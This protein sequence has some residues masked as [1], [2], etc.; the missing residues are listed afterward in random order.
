MNIYLWGYRILWLITF[1]M[2]GISMARSQNHTM[3]HTVLDV[4]DGLSSRT[5]ALFFMG[6]QNRMWMSGGYGLDLYDGSRFTN[7]SVANGHLL[8]NV[9]TAIAE[10]HQQRLWLGYVNEEIPLGYQVQIFDLKTKTSQW[11]TDLV[12]LS[13]LQGKKVQWISPD[14]YRKMLWVI[15]EK[16]LFAYNERGQL[17]EYFVSNR[18][19][20]SAH[21]S[22]KGV[23]IQ[24]DNEFILIDG[25][26][27]QLR[28]FD[29]DPDKNFI[30]IGSDS[31]SNLF[32]FEQ[33]DRENLNKQHIYKNNE[34]FQP[35][36]EYIWKETLFIGINPQQDLIYARKPGTLFVVYD[37][38]LNEVAQL[39][40]DVDFYKHPFHPYF[41][42]YNNWWLAFDKQVHIFN[43]DKV[44]F[45]T[46]LTDFFIFGETGFGSRGIYPANDSTVYVSGLGGTYIIDP[47][48]GKTSELLVPDQ[49]MKGSLL[50][51]FRRMDI[52]ELSDGTLLFS[53]EGDRI[54][55][56]TPGTQRFA[57]IAP[58]EVQKDE[59]GNWIEQVRM[60]WSMLEHGDKVW[61]AQNRLSYFN[62][63]STTHQEFDDYNGYE[64]LASVNIYDLHATSDSIW[65]GSAKGLYLLDPNK[66]IINK[67]PLRAEVVGN[68]EHILHINSYG[69]GKLYLGT[70][71]GVI[72][73]DTASGQVTDRWDVSRGL[74]DN[75]A[76]AVYKDDYG[77]LWVPGNSGLSLVN[78]QN[79]QVQIFREEDGLAH[80]E[81][82]TTS[83]A[84]APDGTLYFGG[85][86]GVTSFH[87]R[88]FPL[89][90]TAKDVLVLSTVRVQK[91][92]SG[93]YSDYN[94]I[95]GNETRL[96]LRPSD[97]GLELKFGIQDYLSRE[98]ESFAYKIE[99]LG[100][101]WI[102]AAS[103]EIRINRLH[104]GEYRLLVKAQGANGELFAT[105]AFG[106]TVV[107]PFHLTGW[108][109]TLV[110]LI[111]VGLVVMVVRYREQLLK[112]R[113][114]TLENEIDLATREIQEQA[115]ELRSLDK[116]KSN[117]FAN[118]SHELKT[119]LSL[120]LAP[121]E[122]AIG[123][124]VLE[125]EL[126]SDLSLAH[127]NAEMIKKLV[128][129]I[130]D[131]TRLE[132][133]VAQPRYSRVK[134]NTF[135]RSIV[136]N[137]DHKAQAGKID[138]NVI[139]NLSEDIE[140]VL[141]PTMTEK[142]IN[143]LISN[144]LRHTSQGEVILMVDANEDLNI[145]VK[146]S[147]SGISE[148]DLPYVFDRFFQT[149][150]PNK[151]A[152]GG[153][154]IGLALS[155]ELAQAMHGDLQVESQLNQG[156]TF[157]LSLP[158]IEHFVSPTSLPQNESYEDY[159]LLIPSKRTILVVED[160]TDL[161]TFILSSLKNQFDLLA[162]A[163]G[164]EALEKLRQ[165]DHDIQLVI[166]D[167]MMPGMDGM[168]LLEFVKSDEKTRH[169]P[170]ILLT[171]KSAEKDKLEAFRL[172]VDDYLTKPFSLEE[173]K[174]R[175]KN[176]LKIAFLRK[177]ESA[178]S[179]DKELTTTDL[180]AQDQW[181]KQL[182]QLVEQNVASVEFNIGSLAEK[183]GESERTF[184]RKIKKFTGYS[185]N[186]YLREIRL[187]MAR[188]TLERN[189]VSTVS[190]LARN[191]GFSSSRYFSKLFR[192]R[193]G[194]LPGDYLKAS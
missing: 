143:N 190:E 123:K 61:I 133:G 42:H 50:Y 71:S 28:S 2:L 131:L 124:E 169:L 11:W 158:Y 64:E 78:L 31:Q 68:P 167:L 110:G 134:L 187:Q 111:I 99:S 149:K 191:I 155:N 80:N 39:N 153:T 146:D 49:L 183:M 9:F 140:W 136:D 85:L 76:Y 25:Q 91:A 43:Y 55:T 3:R 147:G 114:H 65:V 26:G 121:L 154:G 30:I 47:R 88:D 125:T 17:R 21:A 104:Y 96:Q 33:K 35:G 10:D 165:P 139:S 62:R 179:E 40:P 148:E 174:A 53:T 172:G 162:A 163:N 156:S 108:F 44:P 159:P 189:A 34:L 185:P 41:D 73:F 89:T 170:V 178:N 6:S 106:L 16:S 152:D 117:F 22:V 1:F 127:R 100:N 135:I 81:F 56:F 4:E 13:A 141:D 151:K 52:A 36:P 74:A 176:Q 103:P 161:R 186:V 72:I 130:L 115:E 101:E 97:I 20:K 27:K 95:S 7:F 150:D 70:R 109:L 145:A 59:Q 12:D 164:L 51:K 66:G 160:H 128:N 24:L 82:N 46:W 19:I 77:R 87:P 142:I 8:N 116:L 122:K 23:W 92:R 94:Y 5:T 63:G 175:I 192:E 126:R 120:I 48:N 144:A 38:A 132:N 181:L 45:N 84:Q 102:Y 177:L 188:E 157:T 168:Q 69:D 32:S 37:T 105:K 18:Q 60:N 29:S 180:S 138:L 166:T 75:T 112:K 93:D 14:P 79:G 67:Y 58:A 184:Y 137:F 113:Q 83:H 194:K 193:F 129:E 171:A 86:N 182:R 90:A 107:R 57:R 118:I 15:T 54:Y 173:L 119:P 98:L